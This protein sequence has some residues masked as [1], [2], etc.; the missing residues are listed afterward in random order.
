MKQLLLFT[1]LLASCH[2]N[3]DFTQNLNRFFDEN[4][5]DFPNHSCAILIQTSIG[6]NSCLEETNR[7]IK[8][9]VNKNIFYIISAESSKYSH[10]NFPREVLSSRN[11]LVDTAN[12]IVESQIAF[13]Q[14]IIVQLE[15]GAIINKIK[16]DAGNIGRELSALSKLC[17]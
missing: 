13:D 8:E 10:M 15:N 7:F 3:D 14:P 5:V 11:V 6:C 16:V 12:L 1:I 17:R 4:G 9:N 2:S